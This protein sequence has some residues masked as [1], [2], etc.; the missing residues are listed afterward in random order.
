MVTKYHSD[1]F[2]TTNEGGDHTELA[3]MLRAQNALPQYQAYKMK[4]IDCLR[5]S[6][7]DRAIDIG[8]G[9]GE[10]AVGMAQ[11]V[12]P[13]GKVFGL[14]SSDEFIAH[15]RQGKGNNLPIEFLKGDGRAL[16]FGDE[17]FEAVRIDRV[18]Q[19]FPDA[20]KFIEE[21]HRVL[22]INGRLVVIEPDWETFVINHP[23]KAT[24]RKLL[25]A[26]CDKYSSPWIGRQLKGLL[27][28][29]GFKDLAVEGFTLIYSS[30][31]ILNTIFQL[32]DFAEDRFAN[33]K[34]WFDSL[35]LTQER[36][37]F[38]SAVQV[39]LVSGHR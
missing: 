5:L 23:D 33:G 15:A 13:S 31:E 24:T 22:V 17:Q 2:R 30:V 26:W 12:G 21:A 38:F 8:C 18:L 11:L 34:K 37:G 4:S 32:R 7:G 39:F 16:D 35:E 10:D 28:D 14:D 3:S 9:L 25:N 36:G 19:H 20:R 27:R 6:L 29:V 1:R